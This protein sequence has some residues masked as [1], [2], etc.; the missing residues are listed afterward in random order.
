MSSNSANDPQMLQRSGQGLF[1][2]LEGGEG[3]GKSTLARGLAE[4]FGQFGRPVR[5]TRE[6]GGAPI[7]EVVRRLVLKP[8]F[9]RRFYRILGDDNTWAALT[10]TTE[11]L[12]MSAARA[13]HVQQLI[14]PALAAGVSIICDRFAESTLAY[15]G[16]G[17]GLPRA[18]LDAAIALATGGLRPDLIVLLDLPVEVGH[19]RKHRQG[20]TGRDQIGGESRAFHER[21]RTGFLDLA[22]AEPERWLVLDALEPSEKLVAAAWSRVQALAL[23]SR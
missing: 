6:P 12:L 19:A 20:E 23:G 10:P 17:R 4:R 22:A 2:T 7:S 15:Q 9:A 11:L 3:A 18:D 8:A 21:V 13:Q 14:Q 5:I 1:I 16:Y